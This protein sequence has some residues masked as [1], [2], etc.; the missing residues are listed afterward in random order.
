MTNLTIN[1]AAKAAAT[2]H[3]VNRLFD[4]SKISEQLQQIGFYSNSVQNSLQVELAHKLTEFSGCEDYRLF[5]CNSGAEANE[6]ALKLASFVTQKTK[7]ISFKKGFHGRTSAAANVTDSNKIKAPINT[8]FQAEIHEEKAFL[9]NVEKLCIE[10]DTILILDEV[11]SGYGRSGHFF[12]FQHTDTQ[13]DIISMAKGMGNGFPI[14]GVLIHKKHE[15]KYGILGSTFGGNHLACTA[16]IA[17]LDI[18]KNENLIEHSATLGAYFIEQLK[19]IPQIKEVRG[20][21]LMIGIDMGEPIKTKNEVDYF[22]EKFKS[23]TGFQPARS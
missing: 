18:I 23:N 3:K 13:P 14:G 1:S 4:V 20:R 19:M 12:G 22:I 9:E 15:A 21:G 11:Q 17:V 10:H 7:V 5:L 8:T 6:N 2:P 16:G